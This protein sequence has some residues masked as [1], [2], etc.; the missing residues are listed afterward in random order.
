MK[1][2]YG[3][4]VIMVVDAMRADFVFGTGRTGLNGRE[5]NEK[6]NPKDTMPYTSK[7]LQD[8]GALGFVSVA[9]IPT[10]A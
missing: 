3:R 10:G 5:T 4:A 7:L 9:N 8:G 1:A 6:L 2:R